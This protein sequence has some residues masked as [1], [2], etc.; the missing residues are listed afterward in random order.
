MNNEDLLSEYRLSSLL[1]T[2]SFHL[3]EKT[4]LQ[5]NDLVEEG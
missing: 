1:N 2:I 5:G 3:E 4:F